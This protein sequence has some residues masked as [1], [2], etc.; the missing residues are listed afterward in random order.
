MMQNPSAGLQQT[1]TSNIQFTPQEKQQ[2]L[3]WNKIHNADII[4]IKRTNDIETLESFLP[5][6]LNS[7]I[8]EENYKDL[9][10]ETLLKLVQIL[11][12]SLQYFDYTQDYMDNLVNETIAEIANLDKQVAAHAHS[13]PNYPHPHADIRETGECS[14]LMACSTKFYACSCRSGCLLVARSLCIN[15]LS[16][17]HQIKE[18]ETF[19][20]RN[21]RKIKQLKEEVEIKKQTLTRYKNFISKKP[22]FKCHLCSDKVP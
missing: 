18:E 15:S 7:S 2:S 19:L 16:C 8:E 1:L 22:A 3:D 13:R 21:K 10:P 11:Q 6:I 5:N 4:R 17:P 20:K 14:Q 9:K 12:M